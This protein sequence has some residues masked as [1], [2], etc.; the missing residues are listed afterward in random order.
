MANDEKQLKATRARNSAKSASRKK[1]TT[2]RKKAGK[3]S[4]KARG[5][6]DQQVCAA[7]ELRK[8]ANKEIVSGAVKIAKGLRKKAEEGNISCAK[9]LWDL[10]NITKAKSSPPESRFAAELFRFNN[11]IE[12]DLKA[13]KKAA[14]DSSATQ[15]ST[16]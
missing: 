15:N 6:V 13:T 5:E 2:S 11:N 12:N 14:G 7:D 10:A 16:E 4:G 9:F 3:P 1:A 8:T